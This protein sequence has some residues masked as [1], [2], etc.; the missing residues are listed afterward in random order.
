M[1]ALSLS[2]LIGVRPAC[3]SPTPLPAQ[4]HAHTHS[5]SFFHLLLTGISL[6]SLLHIYFFLRISSSQAQID[7][8]SKGWLSATHV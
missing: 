6:T 3:W 2:P 8:A 4:V 1:G 7:K 5:C